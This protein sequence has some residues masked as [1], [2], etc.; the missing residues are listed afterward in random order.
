MCR[1][2]PVADHDPNVSPCLQQPLRTCEAAPRDLLRAEPNREHG[3]KTPGQIQ[4]ANPA[5]EAYPHDGQE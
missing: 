3:K 1:N 2:K 4:C 5:R